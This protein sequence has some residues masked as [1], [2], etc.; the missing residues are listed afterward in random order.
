MPTYLLAL[1]PISEWGLSYHQIF[2][3]R[4]FSRSQGTGLGKLPKSCF[5]GSS[6]SS[7]GSALPRIKNNKTI[8]VAD[9]DAPEEYRGQQSIFLGR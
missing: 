9:E 3:T 2:V 4:F 5:A 8:R 1:E 6:A 7:T